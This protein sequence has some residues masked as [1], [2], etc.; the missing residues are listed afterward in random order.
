M[1]VICCYIKEWFLQEKEKC[2]QEKLHTIM[3]KKIIFA[4]ANLS[5]KIT[6]YITY[7]NINTD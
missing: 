7:F 3:K 1:I 2:L 4:H 5:F 6:A